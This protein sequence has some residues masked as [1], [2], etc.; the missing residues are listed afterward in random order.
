MEK[1]SAIVI[2]M[3][4]EGNIRQCLES[5]NFVDEIVVID[6]GATNGTLEI[7]KKFTDRIIYHPWP[8]FSQQMNFALDQV[9]N[10]W[11]LSMDINEMVS[12]ELKENI[13]NALAR[14]QGKYAGYRI[15]CQNFYL[16][17]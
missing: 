2:C 11:V 5:L 14:D 7:C 15:S 10:E 16:D 13:L 12:S 6:S 4:E 1:I 8:S 9:K 17:R 3:K